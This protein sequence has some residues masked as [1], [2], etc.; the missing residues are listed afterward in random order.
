[1]DSGLRFLAKSF[2][3]W[4]FVVAASLSWRV[5]KRLLTRLGR[6]RQTAT[7]FQPPEPEGPAPA[8]AA[9]RSALLAT[10]ETG[11][12]GMA[13][14][15]SSSE[16][17]IGKQ[18][19]LES[20]GV[21]MRFKFGTMFVA[22]RQYFCGDGFWN[23]LLIDLASD[24]KK[25]WHFKRLRP[26][27][28]KRRRRSHRFGTA[29]RH[30]AGRRPLIEQLEYRTLLSISPA[31]LSPAAITA[32]QGDQNQ[33]V[34]L[35][36]EFVDTQYTSQ[37]LTYKILA[38]SAPEWFSS[39]QI[40]PSAQL[41]AFNCADTYGTAD[42]V[43]EA[44]D[45]AN[46]SAVA[47]LTVTILSTNDAP[48]AAAASSIRVR[49]GGPDHALDIGPMFTDPDN[50]TAAL[51][52]SIDGNSNPDSVSAS[53]DGIQNQ[54][55]L[56]PA[57]KATG[58]AVVTVR[59]TD[60]QGRFAVHAV[61]ITFSSGNE[62]PQIASLSASPGQVVS[63]D[64]ITLTAEK[65][66]D[67]GAVTAVQFWSGPGA[68]SQF[69][70]SKDQYLGRGT[71]NSEG[72][73]TLTTTASNTAGPVHYFAQAVDDQ[74]AVSKVI[75]AGATIHL[76]TVVDDS[77]PAYWE[78][79]TGW[80]TVNATSDIGG[81][82]R[83]HAAGPADATATWDVGDLTAGNYRI[84]VT[85]SAAAT[86]ATDALFSVYDG[87]KLLDQVS[88]DETVSPQGFSDQG[89]QWSELGNFQITK[90][91]VTVKLTDVPDGAVAA[92][93]VYVV[94]PPIIG[95]FSGDSSQVNSGDTITLS[96][97]QY[98]EGSDIAAVSFWFDSNN[99]GVFDPNTDLLLGTTTSADDSGNWSVTFSTGNLPV[100]TG[101]FFAQAVD[102]TGAASDPV[103][104]SVTIAGPGVGGPLVV[105]GTLN[106]TLHFDPGTASGDSVQVDWGDG[107]SPTTLSVS[108]QDVSHTYASFGSYTI[109]AQ[110]FSAGNATGLNSLQVS[111][112][113]LTFAPSDSVYWPGVPYT[114]NLLANY[115][116][117]TSS[118]GVT[119][120]DNSSPDGGNSSAPAYATHVFTGTDSV[121]LNASVVDTHRD[122]A[123][124]SLTVDPPVQTVDGTVQVTEGQPLNLGIPQGN[125]NGLPIASWEID[126]G[127]GQQDSGS[128]TPPSSIAHYYSTGSYSATGY[129]TDSDGNTYTSSLFQ[130]EV[131]SGPLPIS[132]GG[133]QESSAFQP[134]VLSLSG[135]GGDLAS[136]WDVSWGD[137]TSDYGFGS[138]PSSLSHDY[139]YL[140]GY[141][142]SPP[143]FNIV[144]GVADAS[145]V[146]TYT[147]PYPVTI[148]M[149]PI[150]ELSPPATILAGVPATFNVTTNI[151]PDSW[152]VIY[153]TYDGETETE[154]ET[155]VSG[156]GEPP[157]TLTQ[158]FDT[159]GGW[160]IDV[161]ATFGA[162]S[163]G[164]DFNVN[165]QRPTTVTLVQPANETSVGQLFD[166]HA[167]VAAADSSGGIP[168]GCV[169]FL[170]GGNPLGTAQLNSLGQA[171]FTATV[172]PGDNELSAVY[173]GDQTFV[174]GTSSTASLTVVSSTGLYWDPTHVL[175]NSELDSSSGNSNGVWNTDPTNAVWYDPDI[176]SDVAWDI[177]GSSVAIFAGAP[178]TVTA[179][180]SVSVGSVD[181]AVGGY[182]VNHDASS[183]GLVGPGYITVSTGTAA[184]NLP[185]TGAGGILKFGAGALALGGSNTFGGPG[186]SLSLEQGTL[187]INSASALG[188]SG[189][190]FYIFTGTT[191]DNTSGGPVTLANNYPEY[192]YGGFT[193]AGSHALNLGAGAVDLFQDN[194]LNIAANMLTVGGGI[195]AVHGLTE[196]GGGTLA[197]RGAIT[198]GSLDVLGT[199]QL[200]QENSLF[201]DD[202]SRWNAASIAVAPGATLAL[203]VGGQGEFTQDNIQALT[204]IGT[205]AG[206]FEGGSRMGLDTTDAPGGYFFDSNAIQ[207]PNGGVNQL[208][209]VKLGTNTL[210]LSG[211]N[212]MSGGVDLK[213]GCLQI[214]SDSALGAGPL[215]V[216]DGTLDLNG[217][218]PVVA[219]LAGSGGQITS[220]GQTAVI[221]DLQTENT[222]YG[223]LINNVALDTAGGGQVAT[224]GPTLVTTIPDASLDANGST[225]IDLSSYFSWPAASPTYSC[226]LSNAGGTASSLV[227][228]SI[229]GSDLTLASLTNLG[230]SVAVTVTCTAQ[231]VSAQGSFNV[232]LVPAAD[233]VEQVVAATQTYVF[234]PALASGEVATGFTL[235]DPSEMS[236]AQ[237]DTTTGTVTWK[238]TASDGGQSFTFSVTAS[239]AG[240]GQDEQDVT[241]YVIANDVPPAFTNNSDWDQLRAVY[242]VA[243][244]GPSTTMTFTAAAADSAVLPNG[245]P[246]AVTYSLV[247]PSA[248]KLPGYAA[249][250]VASGANAGSFTWAPSPALAGQ[251]V[252]F[253]VCATDL[254]GMSTYQPVTVN[255][256]ETPAINSIP[257]WNVSSYT[258][259]AMQ[260]PAP[261]HWREFAN[262]YNPPVP[263]QAPGFSTLPEFS[264]DAA[265]SDSNFQALLA[266]DSGILKI[267]PDT[268]VMKWDPTAYGAG[269]LAGNSY[270]VAVKLSDGSQSA[271]RSFT[272]SVG[273][274]DTADPYPVSF[275]RGGT[276]VLPDQAPGPYTAGTQFVSGEEEFPNGE[277]SESLSFTVCPTYAG[278]GPLT[279][280]LVSDPT[281]T[282]D[283]QYT[284][285]T[286]Q[287]T[288]TANGNTAAFTYVGRNPGNHW[289]LVGTE[290]EVTSPS[291]VIARM[292]V[293]ISL[294]ELVVNPGN[295]YV[296]SAAYAVPDSFTCASPSGFSGVVVTE[297]N[298]MGGEEF[299]NAVATGPQH[300][301]LSFNADGLF[302]YVPTPGFRGVDSFQFKCTYRF[303]SDSHY[304]NKPTP[305]SGT[306]NT[307]TVVID[308]NPTPVSVVLNVANQFPIT[309]GSPVSGKEAILQI[310]NSAGGSRFGMPI[311]SYQAGGQPQDLTP[312]TVTVTNT[313]GSN[314]FTGY[315]SL[316]SSLFGN[317]VRVFL[318]TG[319]TS[320]QLYANSSIPVT[321]AANSSQTFKLMLEGVAAGSVV[322]PVSLCTPTNASVAS[323]YVQIAM[324][325]PALQFQGMTDG[326][327]AAGQAGFVKL[328]DNYDLHFTQTVNG[329]TTPVPDD[330]WPRPDATTTAGVTTV[331]SP[332]PDWAPVTLNLPPPPTAPTALTCVWSLAYPGRMRVWMQ[333]GA[334]WTLV[335]PNTPYTLA[336]N[337]QQIS[338]EIE[339]TAVGP[340]TLT[341]SA[342]YR[343]GTNTWTLSTAVKIA[344]VSD[345]LTVGGVNAKIAAEGQQAEIP[346]DSDYYLGKSVTG[347]G[348]VGPLNVTDNGQF[349]NVSIPVSPGLGNVPFLANLK[350]LDPDLVPATLT[351]NLG[352]DS[353]GQSVTGRY[354]IQEQFVGPGISNSAIRLW[355]SNG[356]PIPTSPDQALPIGPGFD[357]GTIDFY[358]Q[359]L[360]D[361][362]L[363]TLQLI[364]HVIPTPSRYSLSPATTGIGG[365]YNPTSN[366]ATWTST[367]G[368]AQAG[369][370]VQEKADPPTPSITVV[371]DD[372]DP[373]SHGIP[374]FARGVSGNPFYAGESV[375]FQAMVVALPEG[376]DPATAELELD[377]SGS[378]PSQVHQVGSTADSDYVPA[379]GSLRLWANDG[380]V[381]RSDESISSGGAY[382]TPNTP[383][384]AS[385]LDWQP[386]ADGGM[387]AT[388]YIEAVRPS[389]VTNDLAID[390]QYT[391]GGD[392]TDAGKTLVTAIQDTVP[393]YSGGALVGVAQGADGGN[394][395]SSA[396]SGS[397]RLSDGIVNYATTDFSL[398]GVGFAITVG[399]VWTDQPG[400]V[401]NPS[402]GNGEIMTQLPYL[403]QTAGTMIAVIDAQPYYFDQLSSGVFTERF[404]GQEQLIYNRG[405]DK[406]TFTDTTGTQFV[407]NGFT[408]QDPNNPSLG[409]YQRGAIKSI[410]DAYGNTITVGGYDRLGNI[411]EVTAGSDDFTYS[412]AS[413]GNNFERLTSVSVADLFHVVALAKYS[414]YAAN[415]ASGN[416]GEGDLK[417]VRVWTSASLSAPLQEVSGSYYRYYVSSAGDDL[418]A[419]VTGAAYPRFV[420]AANLMGTTSAASNGFSLDRANVASFADQFA[421]SG[422]E[423]VSQSIVG[424]GASSMQ[425]PSGIAALTYEYALSSNTRDV[426][427]NA[428]NTET[429]ITLPS[430]ATQDVYTNFAGEP[431]LSG[432]KDNSDPANSALNGKIWYTLFVND[433]Q[434]R[435]LFSAQP[436]N[437][438]QPSVSTPDFGGAASLLSGKKGLVEGTDYYPATATAAGSA[439]GYVEDTYVEQGQNVSTK[440]IQDY[441]RYRTVAGAGITVYLVSDDWTFTAAL[442]SVDT[443]NPTARDTHY[444]YAVAGLAVTTETEFLPLITGAENPSCRI[445]S[446]VTTFYS[447]GEVES[448]CDG[449]AYTTSYAYAPS[450]GVLQQTVIQASDTASITTTSYSD[451]LGRPVTTLDGNRNLTSI[452]YTDGLLQSSVS[453]T[454]ALAG[455]D[456]KDVTNAALGTFT[457]YATTPSAG[458]QPVSETWVDMGGRTLQTQRYDGVT[459]VQSGPAGSQYTSQDAYDA[460]GNLY[461]TQDAVGTITQTDFDALGRPADVLVGTTAD[462]LV[463]TQLDEYDNNGVGDGNLTLAIQDSGTSAPDRVT[464]SYYDWQDRLIAQSNGVQ[465]TFNALDNLGEVTESDVYDA[466]QLPSNPI[467]ISNGVP[468][469]PAQSALRAVTVTDYDAQ[470]HV[471]EN[472]VYS[473]NPANGDWTPGN[474]LATNYFHDGRGNVIATVSPGG[475]V[476]VSTT[477]GAGRV[478]FTASGSE[479]GTPGEIGTVVQSVSTQYD[480]DSNPIFVTTSQLNPD[481]A[482]TRTTYVGYWYDAANRVTNMVNYGINNS[483]QMLA[484]PAA[485]A[486]VPGLLTS[487]GYDAAGFVNSTIDPTGLTTSFSN[488][489]LGRVTQEI[490]NSTASP[491]PTQ[492]TTTTSYDG[493][494]RPT[495]VQVKG[496]TP[497]VGSASSGLQ[498]STTQYVYGVSTANG[499][500]INDNDLLWKTLYPD[501]T[502]QINSY[503]SLGQLISQT[504]RDTS[505]H[506]YQFDLAG[507]QILD[508]VTTFATGVSSNTSAL[509]DTYNALGLVTFATS[510]SGG[511]IV[512]QVQNVYDGL[513]NLVTQYQ[514]HTGQVYTPATANESN[515]VSPAVQYQYD[516]Q[517]AAGGNYSRITGMTYPDST[518]V[519]YAYADYSGL[520]NSISRIYSVSEGS[521]TLETYRYLGLMTLVGATLPQPGIS[522]GIQ[523]DNYGNISQIAWTQGGTLNSD[524]VTVS[525]GT[526]LVNI[527]YGYDGVGDVLWR[528]DEVA[529][530]A[531]GTSNKLD[532]TY[533]LD[534]LHRLTGYAQGTLDL[535]THTIASPTVS[536]SWALDSMGNRYTATGIFATTYTPTGQSQNASYTAAGNQATVTFDSSRSVTATYDSWGRVAKTAA[537]T[538]TEDDY[539]S[540][541]TTVTTNYSYDAL[542]RMIGMST[543]PAGGGS[544]TG[545]QTYYDGANPIVVRAFDNSTPLMTYVWSPADGRMI[546]RDVVSGAQRLY[547]MSDG[548]GSIV[549]VA[550]A[551]GLVQERYVYTA[552]GMP[553][554]LAANWQPYTTGTWPF[555]TV[556]Y[557]STLGWNWFYHGQQ[558]MQTH[559]DSGTAQW[560]GLYVTPTGQWY[561]PLHARTLQPNL[562]AYGNPQGRGA[563]TAWETFGA[564]AA[565]VLAGIGVGIIGAITLD[566]ILVGAGFTTAVGGI[567]ATGAFISGT[568]VAAASGATMSAAG[569]WAAGRSP[570]QTA[571]SAAIGGIAGAL[572]FG[573]GVWG[574]ALLS[575]ACQA[576]YGTAAA[577]AVGAAEGSVFGA[578]DAFGQ[579]LMLNGKFVD[580]VMAGFQ[581]GLL[582]AGIGGTLGAI[583]HQVCFT[584]ATHVH[585][586]AGK[587][588][589]EAFRVGQ[590][591]VTEGTKG[592][593]HEPGDDPTAVDP[594]TWRL[595]RLQT[596]K[597]AGS[598]NIVDVDLLRPLSWIDQV[599]AVTDSQI[600]FELAELGIDGPA[601]VLAVESCP[602][603]ESG[604]G[605][606]ITGTF[607]TARCSVLELRLSSGEVLEPTPPHR[608]YSET[609][610]DWVAAGE[611]RVGECLRTAS[612]QAVSVESVA[613]KAGEHRVY[614][615]EVEQEHQFY[616]GEA[617]VLVHNAYPGMAEGEVPLGTE[618]NPEAHNLIAKQYRNGELISE[619][620]F[621]SGELTDSELAL[622]REMG[623]EPE[624]RIGDTENRV[625][626]AIELQEG[627]RL[628]L[629]GQFAPCESCQAAMMEKAL[630]SGAE[631]QYR[632]L[633]RANQLRVWSAQQ[634]GYIFGEF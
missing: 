67:D 108:A 254:G 499:S 594:A 387:Q 179:S 218:N 587:R 86:L 589:I 556:Q 299:T 105:S 246:D 281:F 502:S 96:A 61:S 395:M 22:W 130:A 539:G 14:S 571:G 42:I 530:P 237:F 169:E 495:L 304:P 311:A 43:V 341:A 100:G 252:T 190:A 178:G 326:E 36:P 29:I 20:N 574:R 253:E 49:P 575:G 628:V 383:F 296:T 569:S 349:D 471:W 501:T 475:L 408:I 181:F 98:Y 13:P 27:A 4:F 134:Y 259:D 346:I 7:E 444:G 614:N 598:D 470:G 522:E 550:N 120:G 567:S 372:A 170:D 434:G 291:G 294:D 75:S 185:I 199:L 156:Y 424:M 286:N 183:G 580:A 339:G 449:D 110:M 270:Q 114:L 240:G 224:R 84:G 529:D 602:E 116:T 519:T 39:I 318:E 197:V 586:A 577:F 95:S 107:S 348:N 486:T 328:N 629:H 85:W 209:L 443:S 466:T 77:S 483:T 250:I 65:V 544:P 526:R 245:N 518:Q 158:T 439:P 497:T 186:E 352:V 71:P 111:L 10:P 229:S 474:F 467:T 541:T 133:P 248:M 440:A 329:V 196:S 579:S 371:V 207:N 103:S 633:N 171:E 573:A 455:R 436:S 31:S 303:D 68:S 5:I 89:R 493:L 566:P 44:T 606:V 104:T 462:N 211:A 142:A 351:Y 93:A 188:R 66:T 147:A 547:P 621:M 610:Q 382:I 215:T 262:V 305:L 285:I 624:W 126:W 623:V 403:I 141:G 460:S 407:F 288:L 113:P 278:P 143:T 192:W 553:Q 457:T 342:T 128:G 568:A 210:V 167:T 595:V 46:Q 282:G 517:F 459:S 131:S 551:T 591:V 373:G 269:A 23:R 611:L 271:R 560:A 41:L 295:P 135:P 30:S 514:S 420:A 537:A 221:T 6:Q 55:I 490:V 359:G 447:N 468:Q 487:Y 11:D 138:V 542:G 301:S 503:N 480:N 312:A 235:N 618:F 369:I 136:A 51:T 590:R 412:Y 358:V 368:D 545:T 509:G 275:A 264:I 21:M 64:P 496:Y 482:T 239:L 552:D 472:D 151:T 555:T 531:G 331:P 377:Y 510:Y 200:A 488:D 176:D 24:L 429:T 583:F 559:A 106:Y 139:T 73:W 166:I 227:T 118:W 266:A 18:V 630:T 53:I 330:T 549:A 129:L 187:D 581:G 268:G 203:N 446:I 247:L 222:S 437:T 381:E 562:A 1:M 532:Q 426:G 416:G 404:F 101:T 465:V 140:N 236:S 78:T 438:I 386:D 414:Y 391:V 316:S 102:D 182:V 228:A 357:T 244:P 233:P 90:G 604:R 309:P 213:G 500:T 360:A 431:M 411:T 184:L 417:Q 260:V 70:A 561:D 17:A 406:Y 162:C 189:T 422:Y 297:G 153:G 557:A 198:G 492:T 540:T 344:V 3:A 201:G 293:A 145:G 92:N 355:D 423:A 332:D 280:R 273:P 428:W 323:D 35:A 37:Q 83:E 452:E 448:V 38:D 507:H 121:T 605:R 163:S 425:N 127:D 48:L 362:S 265:D 478:T 453:T 527:G 99:T 337:V 376:V 47:D 144:A 219:S 45:P 394:P 168:T 385:W 327:E 82:H 315:W 418:K 390:F 511:T 454:P 609:R 615:L 582:G 536:S 277:A 16:S 473:V 451:L 345:D 52:Y 398:P 601:D 546:L 80:T 251:T 212:T 54:V 521:Q 366:D 379:A 535:T 441:Y 476:S 375:P 119:W 150:V 241:L 97:S 242:A 433:L 347:P 146:F 165:V 616:V 117:P 57:A 415:D 353:N 174:P 405:S 504:E 442:S 461:W 193:F 354:W 177:S 548:Q 79:G 600:H 91:D 520:D 40:V 392:T 160:S 524:N 161:L 576:G 289:A 484:R 491:G 317:Y 9:T 298:W 279:F 494:D 432:L 563:Y 261:D 588:A 249:T 180:G 206:G 319:G 620:Q 25:G 205:A 456:E 508:T 533:S 56:T 506:Q 396:F 234:V 217:L 208:A 413:A 112:S 306:T 149:P 592:C 325:G 216:D 384:G 481:Q 607:T 115:A 498:F 608:F 335:N 388:I 397:V 58:S 12:C 409:K 477:D 132:I 613:L 154:T 350:E 410:T 402:F 572:S 419:A 320:Q 69:D 343:N 300:G 585:S 365:V 204:E 124:E 258:T 619:R 334:S 292:E 173:L 525:G 195:S 427:M 155:T 26:N 570:G 88:V 322:L 523:L 164:Y 634:G 123:S 393:D 596:A 631:I 191:I 543:V 122:N 230:G 364:A 157:D 578:V 32:H 243:N 50:P 321:L 310:D 60:A 374:T 2:P 94:D 15:Y 232:A 313:N 399:R 225:E 284:D 308:V 378:D 622:A 274:Y 430:A 400:L 194:D 255:V 421:Y 401:V 599:G 202:T 338:L 276:A 363:N 226:T 528:D 159:P 28:S 33:I 283:A 627:D 538:V 340:E 8:G 597:P 62:P 367:H 314:P 558:W 389:R 435:L 612:G 87:G 175:S 231:G 333:S 516:T 554:A 361:F 513:G 324:L 34:R 76:A 72:A 458:M 109:A 220:S 469:V 137:G 263:G 505:V 336:S 593:L 512:N 287:A 290:I 223:G 479:G 152:T 59:A 63:G 356:D 463:S 257:N 626:R 370:P 565:P 172:S 617:G 307:A 564:T 256:L 515:P 625:V 125:L 603:I 489:F 272:L 534:Q 380:T 464:T 267:D 81:E 74:G 445:E 450:T 584:A 485:P 148:D 214:G 302:T 19:A 238:T 632:Y